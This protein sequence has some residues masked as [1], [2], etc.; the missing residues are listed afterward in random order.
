MRVEICNEKKRP[1][2]HIKMRE[3][4]RYNVVEEIKSSDKPRVKLNYHLSRQFIARE[5]GN[6]CTLMFLC[7]LQSLEA[8]DI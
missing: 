1:K 5:K 2:I 3:I 7:H 8:Y 6:V 4:E